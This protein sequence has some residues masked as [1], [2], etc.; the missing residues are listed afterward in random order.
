M[1]ESP[2]EG[3]SKR[4]KKI[5]V[6]G[7]ELLIKPK[8]ADAEAY[9]VMSKTLNAENVKQITKIFV[10]MV[11]RA[12]VAEGIT[13]NEEDIQ[14][15]IAENYGDF[16][17]SSAELFGFMSKEQVDEAKKKAIAGVGVQP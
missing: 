9:L 13:V 7:K 3:Y 15:Y 16:F 10:N 17:Y 5:M 1:V 4:I 6:G 11:K 12:Y 14:D 8:I 2:F